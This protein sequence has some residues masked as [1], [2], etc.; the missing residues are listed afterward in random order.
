MERVFRSPPF[1]PELTRAIHLISPH[2]NFEPSEK[3]RELW[4]GDQNGACWAEFLVL[5]DVLGTIKRPARILEIGP[6][7]G[8]SLVFFSKKLGW[9]DCDL[10]T[11]EGNGSTTKYTM[12]GPRFE[13]SFCGDI[14]Q[15]RHCLNFNGVRNVEIHDAKAVSLRE[16]IGPFDLLYGFYSIGFH[17]S[18]EHFL[19]EVLGL[20]SDT[21]VAFFT[22]IPTFQPFPSLEKKTKFQIRDK[23]RVEGPAREK[24][25]ILKK[26]SKLVAYSQR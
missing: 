15:L 12:N 3:N 26:R 25:L 22:V 24:I 20:L 13:D 1:T 10:H 14:E 11:Y 4:E 16:L 21:G 23:Y 17:W 8:R 18:L 9:D 5:E 6:G 2:L 7:L 19:D